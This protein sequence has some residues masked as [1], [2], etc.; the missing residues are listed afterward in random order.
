MNLILKMAFQASLY[1]V[2][3]ER[4]ARLLT[5]ATIDSS[6]VSSVVKYDLKCH[7]LGFPKLTAANRG[8]TWGSTLGIW[9]FLCP[10]RPSS[11][12]CPYE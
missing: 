8:I 1:H 6:K 2:W 5:T 11:S 4:D 3:R 9:V 7:I 12:L 10:E